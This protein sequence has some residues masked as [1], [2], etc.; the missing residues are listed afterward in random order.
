MVPLGEALGRVLAAEVRADADY[1]AGDRATMDGYVICGDAEPGSFRLT[2]EIQAG[3]T[4]VISI[5]EGEAIR[6]FTGALVPVGGGRVVPQELVSR[7]GGSVIIPELP[8]ARFIRL[9]GSEARR[10]EVVLASGTRLGPAEIAM[11]AQVG[12]VAPVV[13][14]QPV[15]RHIATGSELVDPSESPPLGKIRDT[16][17]SLIAALVGEMRAGSLVSSRCPDDPELLAQ[18]CDEPADLLLI[19][20]GASVGDYDFGAGVLRRLGFTIHFDKVNLKPGKPLTF[21]T[22]GRQ[23][24]FV[25]PG[26]PVSHFVCFQLAVRLALEL[27]G[28]I[29]ASWDEVELELDGGASLKSD[30]RDTWWPARLVIRDGALRVAPLRWATSGDTFSLAG[31]NALIRIDAGSAPGTRVPVLLTGSRYSL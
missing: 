3:V 20:G 7:E 22:R 27:L 14:R 11:L 12:A 25:I 30:V 31:V 29:S 1:P 28:G 10:G 16:N 18:K 4:P 19:S 2:G 8:E 6:I 24:A 15:I 21:A 17:S 26:N 13:A 23:L 9:Q 5:G